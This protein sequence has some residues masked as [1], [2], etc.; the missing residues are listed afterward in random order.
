MRDAGLREVD[1]LWR[2]RGFAL[3]AGLGPEPAAG[4]KT[5]PSV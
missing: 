4:P 3:M 1:C 2:W 5:A